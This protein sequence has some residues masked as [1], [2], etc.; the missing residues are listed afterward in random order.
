MTTDG[1][2]DR[3]TDE[4]RDFIFHDKS[5]RRIS[6]IAYAG[7]GK[8]TT[9]LGY[10]LTHPRESIL[11]VAFNKSAQLEAQEKFPR[12]VE[13]RTIHSL[14]WRAFG[15]HYQHKNAFTLYLKPIAELYGIAY[16]DASLAVMTLQNFLRSTSDHPND[17]HLPSEGFDARMEPRRAQMAVEFAMDLWRRMRESDDH[18][19]PMIPDGYLKMFAQDPRAHDL[20]RF[21]TIILD[22]AQDSDP[23][24][25]AIIF[26][27]RTPKIM[28]VGD[29]HQ[30]IYAFRGAVNSMAHFDADVQVRLTRS[31]RFPQE[32]ADYANTLLRL[33]KGEKVPMRGYSTQKAPEPGQT[34]ALHRTFAETF[35]TAIE[36]MSEGQRVHWVAG[37]ERYNL[38]R[39]RDAYYLSIG[40]RRK[41]EDRRFAEIYPDWTTYEEV[42]DATEDAEMKRIRRI[43]Q[44]YK[45]YTPDLI[46]ALKA[47]AR[48]HAEQADLVI[49]TMHRAKGLEF[50]RIWL[51]PDFMDFCE[52][53]A[54]KDPQRIPRDL[55]L[56]DPQI[57]QEINAQY[58]AFTRAQ[59]SLA[60]PSYLDRA[61]R[62]PPDLAYE[63]GNPDLDA[64]H[65]PGVIEI[66]LSR[67]EQARAEAEHE[68]LPE[69]MEK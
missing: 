22:E 37:V 30:Q 33:Y 29:P 12:N 43:V 16:R 63:P 47:D 25:M 9:C 15:R 69:A 36:A 24:T 14:A 26:G 34:A 61:L 45:D 2:L 28:I 53:F 8:T 59:Q 49:S 65:R 20:S 7:T 54:N 68:P 35:D 58:V 50:P 11:Y 23:N 32:V 46:Q 48:P 27:Q 52:E 51:A 19:I 60:I 56:Q 18:S 13:A 5:A 4:Q 39:I 1:I 3:L 6:A 66:V 62:Q 44:E 67:L 57:A 21:D 41:I 10:A 38:D 64:G 17:D 31:W 42:A 55:I 40:R